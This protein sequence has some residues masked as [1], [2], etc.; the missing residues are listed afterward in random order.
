[1]GILSPSSLLHSPRLSLQLRQPEA[2][3]IALSDPSRRPFSLQQLPMKLLPLLA[4]AAVLPAA[5]AHHS[6]RTLSHYLHSLFPKQQRSCR[7][8]LCVLA[9]RH[10]H[11]ISAAP[12][13]ELTGSCSQIWTPSMYG[14]G[15]NWNYTAGD[16]VVPIGPGVAKQDDWWFRFV[17]ALPVSSTRS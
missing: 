2:S 1:M 7:S 16:P 17:A 8:S 9:W 3:R 15:P 12:G 14:V 4:L 5:Q 6:V 10:H 13:R 11:L